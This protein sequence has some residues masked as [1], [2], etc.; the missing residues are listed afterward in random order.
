MKTGIL[1][2]KHRHSRHN[3][4]DR[5]ETVADQHKV[6][7]TLDDQAPAPP[8]LQVVQAGTH[9]QHRGPSQLNLSLSFAT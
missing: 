5:A 2:S 8:R 3:I 1:L 7:L 6:F 4:A 9:Y